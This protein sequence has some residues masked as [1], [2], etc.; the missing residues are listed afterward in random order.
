MKQY[1]CDRCGRILNIHNDDTSMHI[2]R[3]YDIETSPQTARYELCD[4]CL[5]T[6]S[7]INECFISYDRTNEEILQNIGYH[8]E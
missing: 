6:L 8:E 1:I 2:V 7:R 4:D 5:A 3:L